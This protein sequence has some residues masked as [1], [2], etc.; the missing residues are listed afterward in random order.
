M[1]FWTEELALVEAAALRIEA[2]EA[3]AETRFDSMHAAASARGT[4]DDA[5]GTPEFK[6]WMDA[7]ADT[8]AAWGRWAQV[9]DARPQPSQRS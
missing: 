7:R 9:M 6:A 8:D 3:A 2:L 4:A 1:N 5:L